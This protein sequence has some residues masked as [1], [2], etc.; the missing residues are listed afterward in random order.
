MPISGTDDNHAY[1]KPTASETTLVE[2]R[3]N[4]AHP[5]RQ[6]Q[7][8]QKPVTDLTNT[9]KGFKSDKHNFYSGNETWKKYISNHYYNLICVSITLTNIYLTYKREII[10]HIKLM[11]M[12]VTYMVRRDGGSSQRRESSCLGGG[13]REG[14]GSDLQSGR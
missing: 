11:A 2:M 7:I 5:G 12:A 4:T 14:R 6:R 10:V 1:L 8:L 9:K 3:Q 13:T